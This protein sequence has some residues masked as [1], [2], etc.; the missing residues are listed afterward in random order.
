MSGSRTALI[1]PPGDSRWGRYVAPQA[2]GG[3]PRAAAL[4]VAVFGSFHRGLAVLTRLLDP[5]CG[6]PRIVQLVG[7]ATDDVSDPAARISRH[8]R[9]WQYVDRD[10]GTNVQAS[11]ER[12]ALAHHVP[13]YTGEIKTRFFQDVLAEWRPDVI[14]M[15]T[16]GQRLDR[17]TFDAPRYGTYNFHPSDLAAGQYRGPDPFAD[18]LR[19]GERTTRVTAHHVEDEIDTGHVVGASPPIGIEPVDR[20][21]ELSPLIRALHRKTAPVA[22]A[23]AAYL[24]EAVAAERRRVWTLSF[25][26]VFSADERCRM[27]DRYEAN[28]GVSAT[29]AG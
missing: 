3:H 25:E 24:L 5:H 21:I 16:F 29:R 20:G 17:H 23:M 12:V 9:V 26:R 6:V 7:V 19:M 4:R 13:A 15:A 1:G 10:E 14:V 28:A 22:A 8:R 11:I 2:S 27:L 18:M